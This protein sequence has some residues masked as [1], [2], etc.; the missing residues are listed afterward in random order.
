MDAGDKSL[1][2]QAVCVNKPF[3]LAHSYVLQEDIFPGV[4]S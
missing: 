1:D 3:Q 4:R 2:D